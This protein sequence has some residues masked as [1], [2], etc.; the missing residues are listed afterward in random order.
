MN[1][2]PSIAT[3]S[4]GPCGARTSIGRRRTR[5]LVAAALLGGALAA[6]AV[7][8]KELFKFATLAPQGSIW[9]TTLREMGAAWTKESA[10]A[11]EL[12]I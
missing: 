4:S 7:P 9:D 5:R 12:R 10:G 8:A 1:H 6:P 3:S 11:V 2:S